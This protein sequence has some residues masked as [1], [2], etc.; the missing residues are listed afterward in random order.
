LVGLWAIR[1]RAPILVTYFLCY[2]GLLLV[3]PYKMTRF[4]MPMAPLVL[5]VMF[6]GLH[7]L[8]RRWNPGLALLVMVLISGGI[9][10]QSV[11]R[12]IKRVQDLRHC[13]RSQ[14]TVS[15]ECF[16]S[17]RLAWFEAARVAKTQ[18]PESTVVLTIKE[19]TFFYWTGLKV[20]HPDL[21]EEKGGSD[22]AGYLDRMGIHYVMIN[23]FVGGAAISRQLIGDCQRIELLATWEPRT[24]LLQIHPLGTSLSPT[25]QSCVQME[26]WSQSTKSEAV[27][28]EFD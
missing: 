7:A 10:T 23:A 21:A 14:A 12:S 20:Y 19:A 6:L 1:K 25:R 22:V 2:F 17:D 27:F 11:P 5:M 18:L 16:A 28:D 8:G 9:M 13:D 26:Q 4:Y 15:P 24:A 3:Y